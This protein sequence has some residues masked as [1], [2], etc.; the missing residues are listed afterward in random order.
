METLQASTIIG[1]RHTQ[2]P[3]KGKSK[4]NGNPNTSYKL[5]MEDPSLQLSTNKSLSS[6]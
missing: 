3:R 6:R 1:V 2:P 5:K 4:N